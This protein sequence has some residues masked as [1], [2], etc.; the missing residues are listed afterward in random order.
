[1]HE[2][3][4]AGI[5]TLGGAS[6]GANTI[7]LGVAAELDGEITILNGRIMIDR[8]RNGMVVRDAEPLKAQAALLVLANVAK[9][10]E[11]TLDNDVPNDRIDST[12]DKYLASLKL[13]QDTRYPIKIIG[14]YSHLT[15]HVIDGSRI[16]RGESTHEIHMN[17][18]VKIDDV[19]ESG[20]VVGF[21]SKKDA[22]V[23]THH[24]TWTHFHIECEGKTFAGHVDSLKILKGSRIFI[25]VSADH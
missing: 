12:I 16:P 18:G 24:S 10:H 13:D 2:D 19:S 9:W 5:I 22:G 20:T 4:R 25:G 15:A 17:S 11:F 1:M 14:K 3:K 8:I 21:F 7:G 6:I 23:L